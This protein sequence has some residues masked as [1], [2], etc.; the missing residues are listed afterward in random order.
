MLSPPPS[1]GIR[2]GPHPILTEQKLFLCTEAIF[3]TP[4]LRLHPD[5]HPLAIQLPCG[6]TVEERRSCTWWISHPGRTNSPVVLPRVEGG[7]GTS[8]GWMRL[9]QMAR[10][11]LSLGR[12]QGLSPLLRRK[13]PVGHLH[14]HILK[15]VMEAGRRYRMNVPNKSDQSVRASSFHLPASPE[16]ANSRPHSSLHNPM[17]TMHSAGLSLAES[18]DMIFTPEQKMAGSSVLLRNDFV[19][20]DNNSQ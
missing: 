13:S 20:T 19:E 7:P 8:L 18:A 2:K 16:A 15:A 17:V 6:F 5:N 9:W 3:P 11:A 1:T 12:E 4:F 14:L 10:T